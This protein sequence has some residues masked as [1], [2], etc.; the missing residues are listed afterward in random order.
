MIGTAIKQ[1]NAMVYKDHLFVSRHMWVFS[2]E[3][4]IF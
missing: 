3:M 2:S 4:K 1:I